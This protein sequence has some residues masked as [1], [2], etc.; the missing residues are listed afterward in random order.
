MPFA[1]VVLQLSVLVVFVLA[2]ELAWWVHS[3]SSDLSQVSVRG[4]THLQGRFLALSARSFL[5]LQQKP[6]LHCSFQSVVCAFMQ[7]MLVILEILIPLLNNCQKYLHKMMSKSLI[8]EQSLYLIKTANMLL[9]RCAARIDWATRAKL[10]TSNNKT[11]TILKRHF[12]ERKV[13]KNKR[14]LGTKPSCR[15]NPTGDKNGGNWRL[16]CRELIY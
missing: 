13:R 5:L 9:F 14:K 16:E 3:E 4:A 8:L 1:W 15:R 6:V 11:G 2:L 7:I 12:N 10:K